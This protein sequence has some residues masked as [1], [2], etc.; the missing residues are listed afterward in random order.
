MFSLN[1]SQY[2]TRLNF[3]K[4]S[5]IP[6]INNIP[7]QNSVLNDSAFYNENNLCRPKKKIN[8]NQN[9]NSSVNFFS[10]SNANN[11]AIN[12]SNLQPVQEYNFNNSNINNY[13]Y[14]SFQ[15]NPL[16][17][18][19]YGNNNIVNC[20]IL[21]SGFDINQKSLLYNLFE[22]SK[23]EQRNIK[24]LNKNQIILC[25]ANPTERINFIEKFQNVQDSFIGVKCQFIEENDYNTIVDNNTNL[26]NHNLTY[27][28]S[29]DVN[30]YN[31]NDETVECPKKKNK[32]QKF[33]DVFFNL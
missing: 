17:L 18:N 26:I 2:F 31:Y 27:S 25:F 7:N 23:I 12:K 13:R 3:N 29:I 19:S 16:A 6:D 14:D 15:Q 28:R 33:L 10:K 9:F 24:I 22:S 21:I 1:N 8:Y 11:N 4:K 32:L 20:Y 5:N 30:G